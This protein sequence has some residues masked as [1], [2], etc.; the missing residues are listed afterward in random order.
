MT[1]ASSK[2]KEK[3]LRHFAVPQ[4]R[5]DEINGAIKEVEKSSQPLQSL[6]ATKL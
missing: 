4:L 3:Y 5:L 6:A 1:L 2:L